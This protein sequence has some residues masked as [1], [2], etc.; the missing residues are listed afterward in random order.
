MYTFSEWLC[1]PGRA[2]LVGSRCP[3][4][5]LRVVLPP[6]Y[7]GDI[8]GAVRIEFDPPDVDHG[9][10]AYLYQG[11]SRLRDVDYFAMEG[12][13]DTLADLLEQVVARPEFSQPVVSS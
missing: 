2:R 9:W 4:E 13:A 12:G 11:L 1:K 3:L 7:P 10:Q 6:A 5:M 8:R